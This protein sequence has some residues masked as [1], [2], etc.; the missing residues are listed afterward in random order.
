MTRENAPHAHWHVFEMY[1]GSPRRQAAAD[2]GR[3]AR[4]PLGIHAPASERF[5]SRDRAG[6]MHVTLCI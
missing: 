4:L 2:R 1:N 6:K 3:D 5:R